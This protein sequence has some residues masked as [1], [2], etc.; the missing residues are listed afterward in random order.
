M[1]IYNCGGIPYLVRL[2][3]SPVDGVVFYAMTALHNMLLHYEPAKMD[4][5]IAGKPFFSVSTC[6]Y[7]QMLRGRCHCDDLKSGLTPGYNVGWVG[8]QQ[9]LID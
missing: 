4:V 6:I 3:A 8:Y 9:G 7:M 1:S 2:L 5:R